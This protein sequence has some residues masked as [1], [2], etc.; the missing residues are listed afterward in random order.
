MDKASATATDTLVRTA[1]MTSPP[2]NCG[3][4]YSRARVSDQN[5]P[6]L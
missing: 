3:A 5:E 4:A 6:M 1:D 2:D